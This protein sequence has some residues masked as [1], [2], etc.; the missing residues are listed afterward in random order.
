MTEYIK[1]ADDEMR[2]GVFKELGLGREDLIDHIHY[3]PQRHQIEVYS[4]IAGDVRCGGLNLK[5]RD[6]FLTNIA[7]RPS[8]RIL[9]SEL[10][11]Y[12]DTQVIQNKKIDSSLA[13]A[14]CKWPQ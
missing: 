12:Y 3:N 9:E 14:V 6:I 5:K 11:N 1:Y 4:I 7:R 8:A 2:M 10:S 13:I